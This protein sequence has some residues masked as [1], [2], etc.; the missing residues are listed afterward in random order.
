MTATVAEPGS[1]VALAEESERVLLV[2]DREDNLRA[3][4][5]VLEPLGH[6]ILT[7]TSG[8]E[9]LRTLLVAEASAIVLDV[10]MP[11]M[12]G[13]ET[14]TL[15]KSREATRSIPIVFLTAVG[16]DVEHEIHGYDVGAFDYVCK[17]FEPRVL[18]AKV[19]AAVRWNGELRALR[20]ANVTYLE[21]AEALASLGAEVD[22]AMVRPGGG[23]GTPVATSRVL[24]LELEATVTAPA[25]A[26]GAVR[27]V[28][29]NQPSE[30]TDSV[31]LLVSELLAN[32]IVHAR[33]AARLRVDL[34]SGF[35][36]VEVEDAGMST[37]VPGLPNDVDEHGR[38][39]F[40]VARVADRCGWNRVPGG[41]SVWFE[42]SVR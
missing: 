22:E 28:L 21:A 6:E 40:M 9:A 12:D 5:A 37:P 41:K 13:F 26:R 34:G 25:V 1:S 23:T 16:V 42:L 17:P 11:G 38:G 14:A 8:E 24:D 33:S 15:L 18:L 4:A 19:R 32:V 29:V 39:L 31:V 7:A 36:R 3:L 35:V 27:Q 30:W 20:R 2:D 10:Q